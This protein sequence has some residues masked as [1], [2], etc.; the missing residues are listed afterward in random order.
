MSGKVKISHVDKASGKKYNSRFLL[1]GIFG[2]SA[3]NI[4][5]E[6]HKNDIVSRNQGALTCHL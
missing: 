6:Q 3:T 4:S 2:I 5:K 1:Q